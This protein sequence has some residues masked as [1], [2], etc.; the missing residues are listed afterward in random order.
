MEPDTEYTIQEA[1]A[2]L[3]VPVHKLRRWDAQ[4][5]LV[6]RR[7]EGGHRRYA[8]EIID[9]LARSASAEPLEKVEDQLATARKSLREKR[10]V[11]QL[12]LDSE[13]RYR[14][15]VE[16]SHDLIWATDAQGRFTYLNNGAFDLLGIPP[17]ELMGRCFFDFEARPSHISN[18]RFFSTLKKNGE[19]KNHVAHLMAAD[20]SGKR[21]LTAG[22]DRQPQNLQWAPDCSAVWFTI[23]ALIFWRK[24]AERFAQLVSLALL[25]FGMI[26]FTFSVDVLAATQPSWRPLVATLHSVGTA[27]FSLFLFLFPDGRFVPRWTRWLA[28]SRASTGRPARRAASSLAIAACAASP[29]S[30]TF[31]TASAVLENSSTWHQGMRSRN[32]LHC[33]SACGCE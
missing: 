19:V 6:A 12:L 13:S 25:T 26:T 32:S 9:G 27:C 10:R 11:I 18:R 24:S 31:R 3:G 28:M 2:K 7:T 1:S 15:L 22:L 8:R 23:G 17:K 4:G 5:V 20:G 29:S 16:T 33:A 30:A 14:D 21:P